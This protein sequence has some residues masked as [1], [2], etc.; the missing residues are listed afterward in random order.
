MVGPQKRY[1]RALAKPRAILCRGW[2][3]AMSWCWLEGCRVVGFALTV[4]EGRASQCTSSH[5]EARP[6]RG[7]LDPC[8]RQLSCNAVVRRDT[9]KSNNRASGRLHRTQRLPRS[10]SLH[11]LPCSCNLIPKSNGQPHVDPARDGT[12]P[13]YKAARYL[14]ILNPVW[15]SSIINR[16]DSQ[17]E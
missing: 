1:R 17:S 13:V 2:H 9:S 11:V 4:L 10:R 8:A 7:V 15:P 5:G 6:L 14:A 3:E 16:M 12:W